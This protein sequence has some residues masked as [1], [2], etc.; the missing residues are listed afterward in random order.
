MREKSR[1]RPSASIDHPATA[2][3][4]HPR[5]SRPGQ[6]RTRRL[7]ASNGQPFLHCGSD[8]ETKYVSGRRRFPQVLPGCCDDPSSEPIRCQ[9]SSLSWRFRRSFSKILLY[10]TVQISVHA[11]IT[12][13]SSGQ[14]F[15]K[16]V[17]NLDPTR[18]GRLHQ[19]SRSANLMEGTETS[20]N[21]S[22]D[23]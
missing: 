2:A 4:P 18:L 10:T 16:A 12:T 8:A 14:R 22:F 1:A 17:A 5:D 6:Q 20:R 11:F 13:R 15:P 9:P 7:A 3:T 21:G 23:P 19:T